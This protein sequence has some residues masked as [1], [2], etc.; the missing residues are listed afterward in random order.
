MSAQENQIGA[1]IRYQVLDEQDQPKDISGANTKEL[2]LR[3]PNGSVLTTPAG[4]MTNGSDGILQYIT[5]DG[6]LIPP[7]V[8]QIQA[9]LIMPGFNGKTE[10]RLFDVLKNVDS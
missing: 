5:V 3:K 7:G 2:I 1:Y 10:I 6:D 4:F 8:Y 9:H